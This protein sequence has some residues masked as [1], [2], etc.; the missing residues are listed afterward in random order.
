[1]VSSG[2]QVL[3]KPRVMSDP[4]LPVGKLFFEDFALEVRVVNIEVGLDDDDLGHRV[5]GKDENHEHTASWEALRAC[6][7]R[8]SHLEDS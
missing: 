1:M 6:Q 2:V 4:E 7:L 5:K 3:L 8:N